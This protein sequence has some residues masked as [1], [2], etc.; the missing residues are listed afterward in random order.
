MGIAA[1]AVAKGADPH[2]VDSIFRGSSLAI[3][4]THGN[5]RRRNPAKKAI[6]HNPRKATLSAS[7][8][9]KFQHLLM[10]YQRDEALVYL[11]LAADAVSLNSKGFDYTASNLPRSEYSELTGEL[12][13]IQTANASRRGDATSAARMKRSNVAYLALQRKVKR[14]YTAASYKKI[15]DAL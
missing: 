15:H 12:I 7:D 11:S 14:V 1:E 13:S 2:V 9:A 10:S 8:F 4:G 6:A 5:P 3:E